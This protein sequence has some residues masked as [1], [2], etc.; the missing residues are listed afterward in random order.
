MLWKIHL[1]LCE[2]LQSCRTH[3]QPSSLWV[4]LLTHSMLPR[5]NL[6]VVGEIFANT[7]VCTVR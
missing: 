7:S 5:S 6:L 3:L 2:G 4:V 1:G